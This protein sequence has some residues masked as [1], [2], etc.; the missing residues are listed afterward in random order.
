[1]RD[2]QVLHRWARESD[3]NETA[4]HKYFTSFFVAMY[5]SMYFFVE[6]TV[7]FIIH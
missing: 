1:M 7:S 6:I 5:N 2:D 3:G 4:S